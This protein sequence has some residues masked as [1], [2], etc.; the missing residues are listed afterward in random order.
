MRVRGNAIFPPSIA[1]RF[2]ILFAILR[3]LALVLSTAVFS[4][5]MKQLAPDAFFV[6]QL[7]A[8]VPFVKLL[9]PNAKVLFYGHFPDRLL[10]KEGSGMTKSLKRWYRRPFDAIESWS[11][12]CADDIV[13]NSKFTRSAFKQAFSSMRSRD[14]KVI[15]PCV[16]TDSSK[17]N[18]AQG[19]LWPGK[20]VLLSINRYEGKKNLSLAILGYAGL[21]T[22][23]IN[24]A[25]LVIAGGFD[26]RVQENASTLKHLQKLAD[27]LKLKHTT[28]RGEETSMKTDNN[29]IVF[30]LSIP[31]ELKRRLLHTASLLI[32]TPKNEHFGIVPIEAMLAGVP[33]LATNTGGPLETIYDGRTGWLRS[34]D[35]VELWTEVMRKALIPSSADNL[36]AMGQR[37]RER[38]L[39]EFSHAKMAE[40]LDQEIQ[41]LCSTKRP[42]IVPTW[43]WIALLSVT[44]LLFAGLLG[45]GLTKRI[46]PPT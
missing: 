14:L 7:S 33:V 35:K 5:E 15:Y 2:N 4:S 37:G 40:S 32:Y 13:V 36:R 12:G 18:S 39:A 30:L 20:K 25:K 24:K 22:E 3:Q 21:S 11:T 1:G 23:E 17:L 41:R 10:A 9:Y 42:M 8:C 46:T 6:D 45:I 16:D 28:Y 38:V 29:D 31:D 26:S 34:P 19:P 27:S 44:V 43:I